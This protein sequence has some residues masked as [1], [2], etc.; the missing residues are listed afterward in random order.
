MQS[1]KKLGRLG[2]VYRLSELQEAQDEARKEG[3]PLA[4]LATEAACLQSNDNML[5]RGSSSATIHAFEALKK[6]TVLVFSDS[7]TENH[8]EPG[9]VD[10]A[11]HPPD[12]VHYTPPK[13]VI[14]DADLTKVIFVVPY[15]REPAVRQKLMAAALAKIK[16]AKK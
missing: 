13:V 11:L 15:N 10:A 6:A 4:F 12:D 16:E 5:E 2:A 7:R 3:K 8:T 14:T 9:I 1:N